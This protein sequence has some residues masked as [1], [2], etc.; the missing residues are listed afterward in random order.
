DKPQFDFSKCEVEPG[1]DALLARVLQI[2][3]EWLKI[4]QLRTTSDGVIFH[5]E[6]SPANIPFPIPLGELAFGVRGAKWNL[7]VLSAFF[8]AEAKKIFGTRDLT[9][10]EV[11][12]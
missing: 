10:G 4:S 11:G 3:P 5:A 1:W 8:L 9:L 6:F 2:S 7:D 12:S